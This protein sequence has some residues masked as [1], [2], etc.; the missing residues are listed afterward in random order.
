MS[1][2][3]RGQPQ[4]QAGGYDDMTQL[5]TMNMM[6][7]IMKNCFNDCIGDFKSSDL[8][9]SEK[10]CLQNCSKRMAGSYEVVAQAQQQMQGRMG[11]AGF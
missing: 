1:F 11:G 7:G 5:A 4:Q 10:T 3:G 8:G 9:A 6:M 2:G